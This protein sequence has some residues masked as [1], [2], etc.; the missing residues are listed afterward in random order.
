MVA[1]GVG[2]EDLLDLGGFH[3]GFLQ[4]HTGTYRQTQTD[5]DTQM[6]R[7]RLRDTNTYGR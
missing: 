7:K 5:T 1:V 4:A 6:E 3:S 2:D